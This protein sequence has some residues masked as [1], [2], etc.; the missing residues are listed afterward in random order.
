LYLHVNY[1]PTDESLLQFNA[2][3]SRLPARSRV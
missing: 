1:T 3:A 2:L